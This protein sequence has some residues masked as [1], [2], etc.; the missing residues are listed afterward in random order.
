MR[1]SSTLRTWECAIACSLDYPRVLNCGSSCVA[2]GLTHLYPSWNVAHAA[3]ARLSFG[4][5][6]ARVCSHY[7]PRLEVVFRNGTY[8]E[9]G[10]L[11]LATPHVG[12]G[13]TCLERWG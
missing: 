3:Q 4:S 8:P 13:I 1:W 12:G 6:S 7:M 9:M 10:S 2:D 11:N 5:A